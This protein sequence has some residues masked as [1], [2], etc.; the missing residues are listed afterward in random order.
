MKRSNLMKVNRNILRSFRFCLAFLILLAGVADAGED[1]RTVPPIL[2]ENLVL[3]KDLRPILEKMWMRSPTFR[4]Q[5]DRIAQSPG[6]LVN[7]KVATRPGNIGSYR[8][9]TKVEKMPDGLTKASVRIF[10]MSYLV[11]LVGHEF[12]HILEQIE[13]IN[14][15]AMAIRG[16]E[17]VFL[18][19]EGF[20]ETRRALQAGRQIYKEYKN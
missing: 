6:L 20:Y 4:Q 11:E 16:E 10:Q 3:S 8:A 2:P 5:C 14:L 13:G 19:K 15:Q 1:L 7:L 12:E 17:E 18:S 9:L